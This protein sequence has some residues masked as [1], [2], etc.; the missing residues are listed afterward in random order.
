MVLYG[1]YG[2]FGE[3][4]DTWT[5]QSAL[6]PPSADIG[7]PGNHQTYIIGQVVATSFSCFEAPGGPGISSCIDS[8]GSGSPGQL[9]TSTLGPHTY[10]VTATSKDGRSGTAA[11]EYTVVKATPIL[12]GQAS[13]AV[14][15]GKPVWDKPTLF[16]G[17]SPGGQ[18]TFRLYGPNDAN[19]SRAPTFTDMVLVSGNGDYESAAIKLKAPG[20]YRWVASYSGDGNNEAVAGS[21]NDAGQSVR[22]APPCRRGQGRACRCTSMSR[23]S[24]PP[25]GK[26]CRHL[27]AR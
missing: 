22:V 14:I 6:A 11:I 1:G 18:I 26:I 24:Q 9:A 27:I 16:S 21:C 10:T 20:T 23:R 17:H 15:R 4:G 5:Y 2:P 12:T 3:L 19:C 8:N 7:N 13:P 25:T